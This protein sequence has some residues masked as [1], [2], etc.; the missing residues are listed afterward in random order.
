MTVTGLVSAKY[1]TVPAITPRRARLLDVATVIERNEWLETAGLFETVNCLT[2]GTTAIFPCP[3]PDPEPDPKEFGGLS[4]QDGIKF[5]TYTGLVCKSIGFDS[6]ANEAEVQRVFAAQES[7]AVEAALL[8]QRFVENADDA[9][10][11][12]A[13]ADLTPT[14]GTAVS[15]EVGLALLEGNAAINYAGVPTIHTPVTIASLLASD[16]AIVWEGGNLRS[17]L[18][19]KIVSGGGYEDSTGPDGTDPAAGDMWMYATG[20]VVVARSPLFVKTEMDRSTNEVFTLVE[21]TYIAA[22]DCYTAAVLVEVS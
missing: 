3:T 6:A 5:A 11:W 4:W 22:V 2:T 9:D 7:N 17:K 15:V 18:G 1:F 20:E 21:R 8:A 14:P 12:G 16:N 19:S 13:P 10:I